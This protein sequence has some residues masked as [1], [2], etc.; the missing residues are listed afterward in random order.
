[1]F[2]SG[3]GIVDSHPL[4]G[5]HRIVQINEIYFDTFGCFT[6]QKLSKIVIKRNEHC[7]FSEYTIQG[8]TSKKDSYCASY[9]LYISYKTEDIGLDFNSAVLNLYYQ[10]KL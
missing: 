10:M 4:K 3:I 9:C 2:S 6:P 8:S 1:M 7:L 5:T